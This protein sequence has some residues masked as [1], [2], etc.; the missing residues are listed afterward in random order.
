M[1]TTPEEIPSAV[2]DYLRGGLRDANTKEPL[3]ATKPSGRVPAPSGARA[4][5]ITEL[6]NRAH[7]EV[8]NDEGHVACLESLKDEVGLLTSATT[9]KAS[10]LVCILF[11]SRVMGRNMK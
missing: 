6:S 10:G 4:S 1:A 3:R 9:T 2:P 8:L 5:A 11:L 7:R